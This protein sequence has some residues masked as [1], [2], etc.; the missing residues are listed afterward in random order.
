[1]TDKLST[2]MRQRADSVDSAVPDLDALTRDGDRT[3]R[4]R[5]SLAIMGGVAAAGVLVAAVAVL[6]GAGSGRSDVA[7]PVAEP[8]AVTWVTGSSL[9]VEGRTVDLGHPVAAYVRT[10]E[11]YV[12]ADR[13]GTVWSW[14]D[15]SATQVGHTDRSYPQLFADPDSATA[16]FTDG[17]GADRKVVVVDQQ[18]GTVDVLEPEDGAEQALLYG[19]DDGRVYWRDARGIVAVDPASGDAEVLTEGPRGVDLTD[20][21]AGVFAAPS[22]QST[23]VGAVPGE[24]V[25]LDEAYGSV[26]ALSPDGRYYSSEGDEPAVLDTGT[27]ERIDLDLTQRFATGYE[28][29]D[30]STLAVLAAERPAMS[31]TAQ[32]LTCTV[33][34][35]SCVVVE[36]D[37]GRFADLEGQFALPTGDYAG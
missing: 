4:R 19:V 32:L 13:A 30:D 22:G 3:L 36:D 33:P 23:V 25:R 20:V 11:G 1:M 2:L 15:G 9:H 34:D 6:P 12:L 26:G 17:V 27:G 24:G 31:A 21:E 28:W 14:R 8:A 10:G 37:L 29:L 7:A 35:G 18:H 16:V 5:R